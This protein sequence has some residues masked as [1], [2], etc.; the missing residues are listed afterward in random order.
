M[1]RLLILLAA[2]LLLVACT[3]PT[4]TATPVPTDDATATV[5][6]TETLPPVTGTPERPRLLE[7]VGIPVHVLGNGGAVIAEA[8]GFMTRGYDL[9][10]RW[11]VPFNLNQHTEPLRFAPELPP[12]AQIVHGV[13]RLMT[14]SGS[15]L[16]IVS[17]T[18]TE[19]RFIL[20]KW[21]FFSGTWVIRLTIDTVPSGGKGVVTGTYP[22]PFQAGDY[23]EFTLAVP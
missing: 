14:G 21:E 20:P 4:P 23:I 19:N 8:E 15:I 22:D 5:G 3:Q 18:T 10:V 7:T 12:E 1:K 11:T 9:V 17:S 16:K 2:L 13:A 6:P